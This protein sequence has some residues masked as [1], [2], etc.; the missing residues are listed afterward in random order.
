M[1]DEGDAMYPSSLISHLSSLIS[2]LSSLISHLSSLISHLSSLIPHP[3]TSIPQPPSLFPI[4][5]RPLAIMA[6][7]RQQ[8]HFVTGRLAEHW[9]HKVLADLAPKA[10]EIRASTSID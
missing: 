7:K 2:H 1:R 3:S 4:S 5:R 6:S 10:V 8:I 9:L